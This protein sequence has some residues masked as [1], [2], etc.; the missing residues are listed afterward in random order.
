MKD[1]LSGRVEP[2]LLVEG[3]QAFL[4]KQRDHGNGLQLFDESLDERA[5]DPDPTNIGRDHHILDVRPQHPVANTA[6]EPD[7][8]VAAPR[9]DRR[10]RVKHQ[11]HL[12]GRTFGPPP[13]GAVERNHVIGGDG[14]GRVGYHLNA[15]CVVHVGQRTSRARWKQTATCGL[16][17]SAWNSPLDRTL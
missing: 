16:A 7:E 3:D 17:G 14:T 13:F 5:T 6:G 12:V 4:A 15:C 1:D 9:P 8:T 11:A 10:E 2:R